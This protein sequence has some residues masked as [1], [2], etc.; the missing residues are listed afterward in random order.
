M[1]LPALSSHRPYAA[2]SQNNVGDAKQT[3]EAD[4]AC[5]PNLSTHF[6]SAV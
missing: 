6:A 2:S 5:D 1:D 4:G 3:K